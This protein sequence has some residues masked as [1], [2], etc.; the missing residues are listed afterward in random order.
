[1]PA[2]PCLIHDDGETF[3]QMRQ[4]S[5]EQPGRQQI[6]VS[7]LLELLHLMHQELGAHERPT[8]LHESM[9]RPD[10]PAKLV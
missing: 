10:Q 6:R 3:R 4:N 8:G 9:A 7:F 1:M 2:A 5:S